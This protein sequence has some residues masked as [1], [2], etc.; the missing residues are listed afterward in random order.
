MSVRGPM[1]NADAKVGN[2]QPCTEEV[3]TEPIKGWGERKGI[4]RP[5]NGRSR[6]LEERINLQNEEEEAVR[7]GQ[8]WAPASSDLKSWKLIIH[9]PQGDGQK[10]S[11]QGLATEFSPAGPHPVKG[12]GEPFLSHRSHSRFS[13][14]IVSTSHASLPTH[15]PKCLHPELFCLKGW[16]RRAS[17]HLFQLSPISSELCLHRLNLPC[18]SQLSCLSSSYTRYTIYPPS[19]SYV[20]FLSLFSLCSD[21][22][23]TV[24]FHCEFFVLHVAF[25]PQWIKTSVRKPLSW[26]RL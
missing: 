5:E 25:S 11:G 4:P 12:C 17:S 22:F 9:H 14:V 16:A 3:G 7:P 24:L 18:S 23:N 26:A 20:F 10:G 15:P 8:D 2:S 1:S 19:W 6:G 21:F 13:S